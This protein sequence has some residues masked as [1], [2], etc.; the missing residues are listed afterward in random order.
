MIE[1][2]YAAAR[3]RSRALYERACRLMPS[4][5]A[6]DGRVFSAF[7][8]ALDRLAADGALAGLS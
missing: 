2:D 4:G 8:R 5:A 6:H 1:E 7:D 3:P